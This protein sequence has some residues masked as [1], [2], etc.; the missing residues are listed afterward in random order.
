MCEKFD[1]A[2]SSVKVCQENWWAERQPWPPPPASRAA[3]RGRRGGWGRSC[4]AT[5]GSSRTSPLRSSSGGSRSQREEL[6]LW[7]SSP[8][9]APLS[10]I[11]KQDMITVSSEGLDT[12]F[13]FIL[14]SLCCVTDRF[15]LITRGIKTPGFITIRSTLASL[16]MDHGF[17]LG[18]TKTKARKV[19][20]RSVRMVASIPMISSLLTEL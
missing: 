7:W 16:V 6:L 2:V 19:L 9:P 3:A 11:L 10:L 17:W 5:G 4:R 12:F 1:W 13:Y 15:D 18:W 20:V 14:M 8:W